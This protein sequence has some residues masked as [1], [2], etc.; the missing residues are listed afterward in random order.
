MSKGLD[1]LNKSMSHDL[2]EPLR[3]GIGIHVGPVIVGELGYGQ[4]RAMTAVGDAVN[5]ASRL[6][7]QTKEFGVQAVISAD[8]LTTGGIELLTGTYHEVAVAGRI[9]PL[10]VIAIPNAAEL[11]NTRQVI[12]TAVY[13]G[14]K[15]FW[16]ARGA[17][18]SRYPAIQLLKI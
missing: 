5:I 18:L 9:E 13:L 17:R 15:R 8:V 4:A 16:S 2:R 10:T 14:A 7:T 1:E 12:S 6:E 11:A 3:I